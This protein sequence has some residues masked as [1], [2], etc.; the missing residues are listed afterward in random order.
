MKSLYWILTVILLISVSK[1]DTVISYDTPNVG[2][3]TTTVTT[4]VI[5]SVITNH[6]TNNLLTGDFTDG[7]WNGTSVSSRHGSGTIAGIGSKYVA[8]T[9]NQ[10]DTGLS[11]NEIQRGFSSTLGADIWFWDGTQDQ[12]VTMS[13]IFNDGSGDITTQTRV[14]DYVN[15]GFNTYQDTIVIGEN[16]SINGSVTARF[17]FNH[18]NSTQHR[19]ADL[20]NPSLIFDYTKVNNTVSQVSNTTVKYCWEFNPSTC[21][22]AVEEVADTIEIFEEDLKEIFKV[23]DTPKVEVPVV[24]YEPEKIKIDE[25]KIEFEILSVETIDMMP[26]MDTIKIINIPVDVSMDMPTEEVIEDFNTEQFVDIYSDTPMDNPTEEISMEKPNQETVVETSASIEPEENIIEE[27]PIEEPKEE[28]VMVAQQSEPTD[29]TADS[30]T[31]EV[32]V[33]VP[34]ESTEEKIVE[35]EEVEVAEEPVEETEEPQQEEVVEAEV[36]DSGVNLKIVKLEEY[37]DSKIS[38]ELQKI[39]ATL[40]VVSEIISREM[41]ANQVDISSYANINTALF[42]N[43][44]LPDGNTNFFKQIALVGYDRD[45]YTNQVSISANDPVVK[46]TI[47]VNKAKIEVNNKYK[48]LQELINARNGI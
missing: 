39:E 23:I 7:S 41:K 8:S 10:S 33:R 35:E 37:I 26:D 44:Q 42:D 3:V 22:Q 14:V 38:N 27:K 16:T 48:E 5:T 1:A 21:P 6:T 32:G 17:D 45:I 19:A 43:R 28:I 30:E 18:T 11:D 13:Q 47:E 36:E 9:I 15:T 12:S 46:Y 29:D 2:D 20:K 4:N 31:E 24:T 40:T 34:E 25:P